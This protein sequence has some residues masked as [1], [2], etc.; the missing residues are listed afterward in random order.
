MAS[1]ETSPP[2]SNDNTPGPDS[3]DEVGEVVKHTDS[4]SGAS[5]AEHWPPNVDEPKEA[6]PGT[7]DKP[8]EDTG[9]I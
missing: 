7:P 3:P 2:T 4:G 9:S 5:Q 6:K 1:P 8:F